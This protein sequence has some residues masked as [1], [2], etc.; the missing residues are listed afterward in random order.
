MSEGKEGAG[1]MS[2]EQ[3]IAAIKAMPATDQNK[4]AGEIGDENKK[5]EEN[6][7][8]LLGRSKEQLEVAMKHKQV[9]AET[10]GILND[11]FEEAKQRVKIAEDMVEL[12]RREM[13]EG[14]KDEDAKVFSE[15]LRKAK[16]EIRE[17]GQIVTGAQSERGK[18]FADML[19]DYKEHVERDKSVHPEIFK[20]SKLK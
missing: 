11:T 20:Q 13:T 12:K 9:L 18:Q 14:M 19:K 15:G 3:L 5:I 1:K 17:F 4:I 7:K 10:A 16:E 2:I 8:K 6:S